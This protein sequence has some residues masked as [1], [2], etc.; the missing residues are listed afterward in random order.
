[1]RISDNQLRDVLANTLLGVRRTWSAEETARAQS[2]GA[3]E[4]DSVELS[5]TAQKVAQ[6]VE[7]LKTL[8]EVRTERVAELSRLIACGEY[9]VP[10][11]DIVD[12][13]LE[14]GE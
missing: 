10:V 1:M 7:W 3:E 11:E 12:I 5:P 13:L 8:P 2:S 6:L 4:G 14:G 9:R